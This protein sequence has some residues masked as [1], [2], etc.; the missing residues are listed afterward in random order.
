VKIIKEQLESKDTKKGGWIWHKKEEPAEKP[1]DGKVKVRITEQEYNA[2]ISACHMNNQ[3]YKTFARTAIEGFDKVDELIQ[4]QAEKDPQDWLTL[5]FDKE[6]KEPLVQAA[7]KARMTLEEFVR[8]L[9]WT[10][11]KQVLKLQKEKDE[12]IKENMRKQAI[13]IV[14]VRLTNEL[15][16]KY[17]AKFGKIQNITDVENKMKD[18]LYKEIG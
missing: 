15:L 14:N 6:V 8:A 4:P 5:E 7:D 17:E 16:D 11:V 18:L 1:Y 9:V 2:V 3:G 12:R 13:K 10:K